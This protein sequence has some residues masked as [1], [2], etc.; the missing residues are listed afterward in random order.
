VP[1]D[2]ETAKFALKIGKA[3][4]FGPVSLIHRIPD[5]SLFFQPFLG[6]PEPCDWKLGPFKVQ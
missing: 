4:E 2:D 1:E 5:L 6:F 3:S